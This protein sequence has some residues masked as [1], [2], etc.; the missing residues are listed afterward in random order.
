MNN[1]EI[2]S[3][4]P[5]SVH[6]SNEE[7]MEAVTQTAQ[8]SEEAGCRGILVYSDNRLTDPWITSHQVLDATESLIPLVA[9]QPVYMHPYMV[10]KK[11]ATFSMLYDRPIALNMIAGGFRN[12]LKS[13]NDPTPH[14]ERY[15][16]LY[17]YT[18]IIQTLLKSAQPISQ[19]GRYYTVSNLKVA[20]EVPEQHIPE[21]FV[22]GSSEAGRETAKKLSATAVE[23]P[24]PLGAEFQEDGL[25]SA[26][27]K[28]GI[29]I[30]IIARST[31]EEAWDVARERFPK[32]RAGE[33]LHTMAMKSSDSQWHKQLSNLD[34]YPSESKIYWLGPFKSYNTFCPYLV[35]SFGEVA[36]YL[37]GYLQRGY[38]RIILDIPPDRD[39]INYT[40]DTF[41]LAA[42]RE[43]L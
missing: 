34:E 41:R 18:R 29:R 39:D 1:L 12:D 26:S 24:G 2:Y 14:D 10:A 15:E 8:W 22:S 42:D 38:N 16:R 30:G 35:G 32:T 33:L 31:N 40:M 3:T 7:Y 25:S 36:E 6:Y 11:I 43:V 5:Q 19:E 13:L 37:Q 4:C 23:Y 21:V 9:V 28:R 17:E 20:P 27:D